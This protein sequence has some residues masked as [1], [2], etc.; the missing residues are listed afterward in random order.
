M[1]APQV[2]RSAGNP[3]AMIADAQSYPPPLHWGAKGMSRRCFHLSLSGKL[4]LT[5]SREDLEEIDA[6]ESS[7]IDSRVECRFWNDRACLCP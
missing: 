7:S 1:S 5:D 6:H 4:L 2:P 3:F